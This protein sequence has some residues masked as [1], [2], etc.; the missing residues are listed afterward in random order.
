M[1]SGVNFTT[2]FAKVQRD[3]GYVLSNGAVD[4]NKPS[5]VAE[6]PATPAAAPDLTDA[7][8]SAA[9][10]AALIR[11]RQSQ[12]RRS[13]FLTGPDGE[14]STPPAGKTSMMGGSY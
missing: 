4:T 2:D 11:Q 8:L 14:M 6:G 13:S 1:G 10:R 9:D 5:P 7:M 12:G 3:E